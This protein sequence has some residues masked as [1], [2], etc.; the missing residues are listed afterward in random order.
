V[1]SQVFDD[2]VRLYAKRRRGRFTCRARRRST[3]PTISIATS[4]TCCI[5]AKIGALSF[6]ISCRWAIRLKS[7]PR[8]SQPKPRL[9]EPNLGYV[10][11]RGRS[12]IHAWFRKQ[13]RDKNILAGRSDDELEHLG[14]SLKQ[15]ASAAALQL[16]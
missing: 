8:S 11:S 1:R 16:Q 10:T 9:A 2:R 15:K 7:L 14:I 3:L 13:D 12:K 5:G 6:P 4:A